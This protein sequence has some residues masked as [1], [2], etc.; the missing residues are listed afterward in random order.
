M[1]DLLVVYALL[2]DA[3]LDH[4]PYPI[5]AIE[6]EESSRADEERREFEQRQKMQDDVFFRTPDPNK[7]RNPYYFPD[8]TVP[9]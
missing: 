4:F 8:S 6:F 7:D 5:P 3:S 2:A 9:K 1:I